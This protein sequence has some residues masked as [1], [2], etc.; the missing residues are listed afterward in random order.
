[1]SAKPVTTSALILRL[2]WEERLRALPSAVHAVFR[3]RALLAL[4]YGVG[5]LTPDEEAV[6][7]DHPEYQQYADDA[8]ERWQHMALYYGVQASPGLLRALIKVAEM[9]EQVRPSLLPFFLNPPERIVVKE[10]R[11]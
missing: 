5:A 11:T 10:V 9:G 4:G 2:F 7:A 6:V 3:K 8:L 1:M